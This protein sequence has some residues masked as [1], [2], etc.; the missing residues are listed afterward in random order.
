[1]QLIDSS[2]AVAATLFTARTQPSGN[3][4]PGFGLPANAS[5]LT[6]TTTAI[7]PGGPAWSPLGGDSGKCF[8]GGCGYTSWIQADYTISTAGTYTL[9]FGTSNFS[10]TVYNTGLA[11]DGV[12]IA[13][14][15][16]ITAA[17]EPA[18]MML[19]GA[20]LAGIG[21]IRRRRAG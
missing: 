17:P 19:M 20:G 9:V 3:T 15:T 6:P 11:I 18:S 4:S 7:I 8:S 14:T 16:I 10:D 13:G 5:T 1:M 2:S 12:T 21:L